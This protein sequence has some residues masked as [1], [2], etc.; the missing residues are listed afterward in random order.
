M[1]KL[2]QSDIRRVA[3]GHCRPEAPTDPY[4]LALEHSVPQVM[5]SLPSGTQCRYPFRFR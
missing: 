1:L 4:A 5:G 3:S 2:R